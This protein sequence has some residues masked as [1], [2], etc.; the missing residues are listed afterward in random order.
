MLTRYFLEA[1]MQVGILVPFALLLQNAKDRRSILRIGLFA[2]IFIAYQ[3]VLVL[4]RLIP[5][6]DLF[7]SNWNWEGKLFGI[8][9]GILCYLA[10]RPLFAEQDLVKVKQAEGAF[11]APLAAAIAIVVLATAVAYATGKSEFSAETLLFQLTMPGFDEELMFRS[12]LL[13]LLLVSLRERLPVIGN[14]AVL[15]TAVLF[16]FMHALTLDKNLSVSFEPI[17]FVQTGIGGFVWAWIAMRTRS[18]L[19]PILSH[20]LA[21]FL[22]AAVTMVG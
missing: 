17:Y 1:L 8:V 2:G 4:P 15:I 5:S 6:L 14:P 18:I 13:G 3:L 12:V 20:N 7:G 16:G 22:A 10:F 11:R 21:N 19:L 9:F